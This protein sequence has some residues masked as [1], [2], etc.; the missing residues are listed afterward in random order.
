MKQSIRGSIRKAPNAISW[1]F[2][3]SNM[4]AA[5]KYD[6]AQLIQAWS[7]G[8]PVFG[9]SFRHIFGRLDLIMS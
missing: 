3:L 7:L 8:C 6:P 2:S 5:N 1:V 4:E 9:K